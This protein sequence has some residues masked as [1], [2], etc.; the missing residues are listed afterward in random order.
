MRSIS[1]YLT[2]AETKSG[3]APDDKGR[4]L[5]TVNNFVLIM[6][7]DRK[8]E[9]VRYNELA[10]CA[11]IHT[12]SKNGKLTIRRLDPAPPVQRSYILTHK[13]MQDTP[14]FQCFLRCCE[15]YLDEKPYLK[16]TML[17]NG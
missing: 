4:P 14:T 11:E 9:S 12:I 1:K 2:V 17:N 3:L 13:A 6:V 16:K 8:Y 15:A 5:C 7:Q 10:G